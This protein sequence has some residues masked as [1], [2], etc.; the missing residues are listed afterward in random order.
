MG[1][2]HAHGIGQGIGDCRRNRVDAALALRFGTERTDRIDRVGKEDVSIRGV[3]E[4]RDATIAQLRI[5]HAPF[6]VVHHI[7]DERP[8]VAH[9]YGAI[10]LAAALHRIDRPADIGRMHA[11]QHT[12]LARHAMHRESN[13]L[14]VKRDRA[15]RQIGPTAD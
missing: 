1:E 11:V 12:D 14:D 10:E 9:R 8:A 3:R 7:L 6:S 2:A 15:R 5:D 13:P 4:G